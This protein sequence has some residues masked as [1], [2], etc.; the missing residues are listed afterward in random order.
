ME[1]TTISGST[2]NRHLFVSLEFDGGKERKIC[3]ID[4][5][6]K[7]FR[8]RAFAETKAIFILCKIGTGPGTFEDRYIYFGQC[9]QGLERLHLKRK[10]IEGNG[11]K[12][13]YHRLPVH[14]IFVVNL[15]IL[16]YN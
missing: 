10:E 6:Q 11:I 4:N 8:V 2:T 15:K 7:K 5:F 1:G 14:E 12:I 13:L 16:H 9:R 3:A